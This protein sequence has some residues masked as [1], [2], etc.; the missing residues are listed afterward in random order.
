MSNKIAAARKTL[1][2][3]IKKHAE[4]VGGTAVSLKKA[5]R[6]AAEIQSAASA[7]AKLVEEK[8]GIPTPFL[9]LW[10]S[11]LEAATIASL[12]AERDALA[13]KPHKNRDK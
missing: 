10:N 3:A 1:T 5:Q 9:T 2:K 13:R 11:G 6:A 8:T 4:I 7:Y 12:V